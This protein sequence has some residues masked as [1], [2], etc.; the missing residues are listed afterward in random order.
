[1][2]VTRNSKLEEKILLNA[3]DIDALWEFNGSVPEAFEQC[4]HEIIASN[5]VSYPEKLAVDAWDGKLSYHE[6][7]QLSTR[8]AEQLVGFGVGPEDIVPLCFEKSM[9]TVVAIMGVLK[10]G[11]AFALLDVSQPENRLREII[12]Q[13][14]SKVVCTSVASQGLCTG[15][16]T[17]A[18]VVGP[19][20]IV[21]EQPAD[22]AFIPPDYDPLRSIAQQ[23]Q[24]EAFCF[25]PE[26][27]V[28]DFASYAFD[29]SV[30]NVMMALSAGA[31]L[32]IPSEEQRKGFWYPQNSPIS[33]H[34]YF[35]GKLSALMIC[36]G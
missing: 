3:E 11:G 17:P 19:E 29:V 31:C 20:L 8:L 25:N 36:G 18:H 16:P 12:Q 33:R 27:R 24:T 10:A 14:R 32:V 7:D 1:M 9:W 23:H 6:L 26:A 4:I 15:A 2:D 5:V 35:P 28:F 22:A 34:S 13:C 21:V 30:Y